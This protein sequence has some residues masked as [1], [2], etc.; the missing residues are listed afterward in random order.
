M[1]LKTTVRPET[2]LGRRVFK[3]AACGLTKLQHALQNKGAR[4]ENDQ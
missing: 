3:F 2:G 4:E 1:I